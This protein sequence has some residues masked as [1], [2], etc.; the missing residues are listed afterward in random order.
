MICPYCID[1]EADS[2]DHIFAEFLG[3][4]ARIPSCTGCNSIFDYSFEATAFKD[5]RELM[6]VLRV[7]GMPTPAKMTW[8]RTL[9][10]NGELY[11]VDQDLRATRSV[12][13]IERNEHGSIVS[14]QGSRTHVQQI[15]RSIERRGK[16]ARISSEPPVTVSSGNF[17]NRYHFNDD[18]KRTCIKMSIAAARRMEVRDF[19]DSRAL[20]YLL[21]AEVSDGCPVRIAINEYSSLD[22]QRTPASHLIYVQASS[23]E[24]RVY[25]VVQFFSAFQFYCELAYNYDGPDW[26]ILATHDS[27]S[28]QEA[29]AF[30]AP[31][32]YPVPER[33]VARSLQDCMSE[34]LER[35]RL[36]LVDL[37]GD[38]TSLTFSTKP[39]NK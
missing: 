38:R 10:A 26:A 33:H 2:R 21:R 29:F 37:Y 34:R 24:H 4:K 25:S 23:L 6:F 19:A 11:D 14:A 13:L 7:A 20:S 3:G 30:V 35:L 1:R 5:F 22:R 17:H 9:G 28:H 8:R 32:D 36:E 16:R 18:V 15:A 39:L 31:L 12:P 27:V